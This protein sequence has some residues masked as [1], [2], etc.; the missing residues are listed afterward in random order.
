MRKPANYAGTSGGMPG[1][2]ILWPSVRME[3]IS[4]HPGLTRMRRTRSRHGALCKMQ[5]DFTK[6]LAFSG[7]GKILSVTDLANIDVIDLSNG[8]I[9]EVD[10]FDMGHIIDLNHNG[11]R[12]VDF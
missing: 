9:R 11:W 12:I 7:N 4:F 3:N 5:A 8:E 10:Q 2:S 6:T 1:M